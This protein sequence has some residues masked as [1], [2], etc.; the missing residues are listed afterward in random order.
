MIDDELNANAVTVDDNR[1]KLI[2]LLQLA[3]SGELAAAYAYRGHWNSVRD[4]NQR[5]SI[6]SI[7]E[8]EWRHRELVGE[9][10]TS[11]A[12]APEK[13]RELRATITGRVLG[14]LCVTS[15]GG[16]PQ[17]TAQASWRAGTYEST[18]W[19][20]GMRAIATGRI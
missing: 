15:W 13:W 10:L 5:D 8:D 16:W 20:R 9:M 12:A 6:Q 4:A 2:A 14:L 17:C 18:R 11:L 3:Y 7:E 19:P 1:R